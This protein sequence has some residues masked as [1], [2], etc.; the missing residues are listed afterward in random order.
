MAEPNAGGDSRALT[1]STRT[2]RHRTP[3]VV[4]PRRP[5]ARCR[6][7]VRGCA[8]SGSGGR[9][10]RVSARSADRVARAGALAL[11]YNNWRTGQHSSLG[12]QLPCIPHTCHCGRH[13]S[14][15]RLPVASPTARQVSRLHPHHLSIPHRRHRGHLCGNTRADGCV[16]VAASSDTV[17][18]CSTTIGSRLFASV[19][20]TTLAALARAC[21]SYR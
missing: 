12:S 16:L 10:G 8:P 15:L 2:T 6:R 14:R 1:H 13:H 19:S 20:H 18:R 17:L 9:C 21:Y 7:P 11:D 5:L 3:L 4:T